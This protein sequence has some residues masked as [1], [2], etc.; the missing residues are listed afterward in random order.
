MNNASVSGGA[1]ASGVESKLFFKNCTIEDDVAYY[2]AGIFLELSA[3]LHLNET[4]IRNNVASPDGHGGGIYC[5]NSKIF[6]F[7]VLSFSLSVT[8]VSLRLMTILLNL[9][10]MQIF[11]VPPLQATRGALCKEMRIGVKSVVNPSTPVQNPTFSTSCL[12]LQSLE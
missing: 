3:Q 4:I 2:G 9:I 8:V 6:V 5:S 12:Q 11:I 7:Q 10:Q 1:L